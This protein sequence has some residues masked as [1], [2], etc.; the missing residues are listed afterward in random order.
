MYTHKDYLSRRVTHTHRHRH[1]VQVSFHMSKNRI[2]DHTYTIKQKEPQMYAYHIRL[3]AQKT[4]I[5][6]SSTLNER[7]DVNVQDN[8]TKANRQ[9]TRK[10]N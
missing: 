9:L 3:R 2:D 5:Q 1:F 8:Q 6:L 4:E 10:I 7:K